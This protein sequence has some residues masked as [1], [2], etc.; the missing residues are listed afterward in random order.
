MGPAVGL[1]VPELPTPAHEPETVRRAVESVL[2]RPEFARHEPGLWDRITGWLSERVG[3]LLDLILGS[4]QAPT[5]GTVMLVVAL[6]AGLL[7]AAW[8]A[9]GVR[10]GGAAEQPVTTAGA[11]RTPGDWLQAAAEA[12]RDGRWREALRCRYRWLVAELDRRGAVDEEEGRTT[13][14][15]L[16]EVRARAPAAAAAFAQATSTFEAVW[17][18]S[19]DVDP[20][21]VEAF[22]ATA[23]AV[24]ETL[25]Q[26]A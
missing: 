21:V 24:H 15:Y 10:R 14:E 19:A 20:G 4:G 3:E 11:G 18:G 16:A 6:L 26:A 1:A 12:E 23:G 2:S 8:F 13:G 9:R 22:R 25:G 17:Y 5:L 7:A